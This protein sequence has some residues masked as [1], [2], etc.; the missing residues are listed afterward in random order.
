M[1]PAS[2]VINVFPKMYV[3]EGEDYIAGTTNHKAGQILQ[4]IRIRQRKTEL[5]LH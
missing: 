4:F 2:N 5:R 3:A 1:I